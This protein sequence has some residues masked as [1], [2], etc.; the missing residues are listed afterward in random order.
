MKNSTIHK[1][2]RESDEQTC[3]CGL[4]WG[5]DEDD[6]HQPEI[7][8]IDLSP[9]GGDRTVEMII[10]KQGEIFKHSTQEQCHT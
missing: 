5:I 7:I 2:R 9:P 4:R 10:K 8:G 1:V 3:S 6:P